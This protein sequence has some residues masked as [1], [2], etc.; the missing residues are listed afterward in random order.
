MLLCCFKEPKRKSSKQ[1]E[2]SGDDNV[3]Y[4]PPD[5]TK[6]YSLISSTSVASSSSLRPPPL[7]A[8]RPAVKEKAPLQKEEKRLRKQRSHDSFRLLE[9]A[10]SLP[11]ID[12]SP[13]KA[14]LDNKEN[15]A[16]KGKR[17]KK[18]TDPF[19]VFRFC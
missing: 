12:Q 11:Y 2:I 14:R 13:S 7:R 16:S 9:Q 10:N 6:R 3:P 4:E 15:K 1:N 19:D 5:N 17:E 8:T 18:L